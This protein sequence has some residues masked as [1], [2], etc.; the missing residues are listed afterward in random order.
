MSTA[1][2]APTIPDDDSVPASRIMQEREDYKERWA[3]ELSRA[4]QL[5]REL[6]EAT[7][8]AD[9]W[10]AIALSNGDELARERVAHARTSAELHVEKEATY[11]ALRRGDRFM[12]QL[13]TSNERAE[14]AEQH[15]AASMKRA[16]A[17]A[18]WIEDAGVSMSDLEDLIREVGVDCR[19]CATHGPSDDCDP[20][21]FGGLVLR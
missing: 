21:C 6:A 16:D 2:L 13:A 5:E 20:G 1:I 4:E 19:E 11:A 8:S 14:L 18:K 7:R 10:R 12:H 9:D 3:R 17:L 15:L